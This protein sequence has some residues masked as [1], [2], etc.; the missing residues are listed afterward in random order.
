MELIIAIFGGYLINN[1]IN[2]ICWIEELRIK[3][4]F[5]L[6]ILIFILVGLAI[7]LAITSVIG[8]VI[9]MLSSAQR[10]NSRGPSGS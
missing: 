7:V 6:N 4:A 1:L 10:D 8:L 5:F 3:I 9:T 2:K